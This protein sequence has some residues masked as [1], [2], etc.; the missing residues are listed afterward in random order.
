[1]YIDESVL[2]GA[3][4]GSMSVLLDKEGN[5]T[6]GII[7]INDAD[8]T[9]TV[10]FQNYKFIQTEELTE[11]GVAVHPYG[12]FIIPVTA[13]EGNR[14]TATEPNLKIVVEF[15]G[16]LHATALEFASV[17]TPIIFEKVIE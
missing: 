9:P 3:Y 16:E 17:G 8:V 11:A 7:T 12:G 5:A 10:A 6:H 2:C 4:I 15:D 1:M 13:L 14:R